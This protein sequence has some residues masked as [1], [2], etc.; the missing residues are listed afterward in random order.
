MGAQ[1]PVLSVRN[2]QKRFG[3]VQ[4]LR[5]VSLEAYRGEVLALLGDN[6][7][8]QVDAGEMHQRRLCAG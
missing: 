8:R 5:D 4:A 2:A 7:A 3:P 6:G 1:S